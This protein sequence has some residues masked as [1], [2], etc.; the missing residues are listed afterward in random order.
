R[1]QLLV[2]SVDAAV[3]ALGGGDLDAALT[4]L[5]EPVGGIPLAARPEAMVRLHWG[6]LLLAGR[7]A[8]AAELTATVGGTPGLAVRR[9]LQGVARFLDG[10]PERLVGA[11]GDLDSERYEL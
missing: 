4:I 1:L 7:A 6:F 2:T 11:A 3:A 9:E 5:A 8:E 10:D